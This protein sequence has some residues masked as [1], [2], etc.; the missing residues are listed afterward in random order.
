MRGGADEQLWNDHSPDVDR[1]APWIVDVAGGPGVSGHQIGKFLRWA[2]VEEGIARDGQKVLF[3]RNGGINVG[4]I[5]FFTA[6][7][8]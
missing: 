4:R 8:L 1:Y 7:G 3:H 5:G 2:C 6:R